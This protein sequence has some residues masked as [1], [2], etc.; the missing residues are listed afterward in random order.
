MLKKG[1]INNCEKCGSSYGQYDNNPQSDW[2][3]FWRKVPLAENGGI[4]E[5]KGLCQFCN[6]KSKHSL[7]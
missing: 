5:P 4:K 6:P 7:C 3:E 2:A 1:Q